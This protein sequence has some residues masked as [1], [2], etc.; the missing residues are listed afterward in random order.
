MLWT[1]AMNRGTTVNPKPA[2]ADLLSLWIRCPELAAFLKWLW[3]VGLQMQLTPPW[4]KTSLSDRSQDWSYYINFDRKT[5]VTNKSMVRIC[6]QTDTDKMDLIDIINQSTVWI[7]VR[8][9]EYHSSDKHFQTYNLFLEESRL[10]TLLQAP[11][12]SGSPLKLAIATVR[13]HS[14]VNF[15]TFQ[16]VTV[17]HPQ[18]RM[19]T[20]WFQPFVMSKRAWICKQ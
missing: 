17:P 2:A 12:T 11:W 14:L 9:A 8:L 5:T 16:H 10:L 20:Q 19:H 7:G 3:S 4:R 6:Y 18:T 15:F 13:N 1:G